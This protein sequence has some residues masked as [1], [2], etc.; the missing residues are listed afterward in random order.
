MI[1]QIILSIFVLSLCLATL[2]ITLVTYFLYRFKQLIKLNK[3]DASQIIDGVFFKKYAPYLKPKAKVEKNEF[4]NKLSD[5]KTLMNFFG[6]IAGIIFLSLISGYLYSYFRLGEKTIDSK[7]YEGLLAKGLMKEFPLNS[8]QENPEFL[9]HISDE[10]KA[11]LITEYE[12]LNKYKIAIYKVENSKE[13][14]KNQ[15]LIYEGWKLLFEKYKV[16]F[17]TF[18]N[19]LELDQKSVNLII[20]PNT[21]S[22]NKKAKLELESLINKKIPVLATG[23]VAYF[24]GLGDINKDQFSEKVFGIKLEK[25]GQK[26]PYYPTLFKGNSIPWID[27]PPGMLINYFPFDNQFISYFVSG[28]SSIYEGNTQ[29]EIHTEK[30]NAGPVVRGNFKESL[31]RTS[32]LALNPPIKEQKVLDSDLYYLELMFIKSMQWLLNIPEILKPA[33]KDFAKTVFVPS[34]EIY[35]NN[36][37]IKN[38]IDIFK[39]Y[40][41]PLTIYIT[42]EVIQEN[43]QLIEEE[44]NPSI[45]FASLGEDDKVLQGNSLQIQFQDIQNSRLLLEEAWQN[46]VFGFKAAEAKYDPITLNAVLQNGLYYFLGNQTLFRLSPVILGESSLVYFPKTYAKEIKMFK[47]SKFHN[48]SLL[49]N[50]LLN[51]FNEVDSLNGAAFFNF[52][53]KYYGSKNLE[54]AVDNFLKEI[55]SKNI[56]KT[57]YVNLALWWLERENIL[58]NMIYD[59]NKYKIVI[60]NNNDFKIENLKIIISNV[61]EKKSVIFLENKEITIE[62]KDSFNYF[63]LDEINAKSTITLFLQDK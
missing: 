43:A 47:A 29:A 36:N 60:K 21:I 20:L 51:R 4:D 59:N 30:M 55:S 22:L 37:F 53:S 7:K 10:K 35:E 46:K 8:L 61:N 56:W 62:S 57:N 52:P 6:I 63:S 1:I 11:T 32:W 5:R 24:D 39:D 13:F 41:F 26:R 42:S 50:D 14:E 38:Y 3:T 15:N 34:L 23:P 54:K 9:E 18:S 16:K 49:Y 28:Y 40:R 44:S 31:A 33:W 19:F 27:V 12:K 17:I 45:E 2:F 48:A 25:N 58:V